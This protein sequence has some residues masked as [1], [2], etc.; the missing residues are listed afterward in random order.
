[1]FPNHRISELLAAQR[2]KELIAEAEKWR[3][4]YSAGT[5]S[6]PLNEKILLGLAEGLIRT[7]RRIQAAHSQ[8]LDHAERQ[9]G[10]EAC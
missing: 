10:C 4:A 7:G 3:L 8:A 9:E 6:P 2:Q 1:M 5:K